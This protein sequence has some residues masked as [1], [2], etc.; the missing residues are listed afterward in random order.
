MSEGAG[1]LDAAG[2]DH[3]RGRFWRAGDLPAVVLC[4]LDPI[5]GVAVP[6]RKDAPLL[7]R[8]L[9]SVPRAEAWIEMVSVGAQ[10]GAEPKQKDHRKQNGHSRGGRYSEWRKKRKGSCGDRKALAP[11]YFPRA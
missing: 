5:A 4:A 7:I 1:A 8:L 9:G 3:D 6:G 10:R 11:A 2:Q